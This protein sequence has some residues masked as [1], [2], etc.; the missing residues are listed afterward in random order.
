MTAILDGNG[1]ELI[2]VV[3]NLRPNEFFIDGAY[4]DYTNGN[5]SGTVHPSQRSLRLGI[6]L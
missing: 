6:G 3:E 5:N 4:V 1:D 2:A